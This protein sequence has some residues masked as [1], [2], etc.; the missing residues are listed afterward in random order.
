MYP[1]AQPQNCKAKAVRV[2]E[3]I[4]V[5]TTIIKD[6]KLPS[7]KLQNEQTKNGKDIQDLNKI[8]NI[9]NPVHKRDITQVF[10][11]HMI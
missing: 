2:T 4:D 11:A 7:Q 8:I 6:L 10:Q 5:L 3:E 1:T 9:W